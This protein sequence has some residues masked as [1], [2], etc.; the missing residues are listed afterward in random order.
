MPFLSFPTYISSPLRAI[1]GAAFQVLA[2]PQ[3]RSPKKVACDFS[4]PM[5]RY[6]LRV[7]SAYM[8]SKGAAQASASWS[9][10]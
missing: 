9:I 1:K 10:Q 2:P 3:S 6:G 7:R 5:T 4:N 8:E